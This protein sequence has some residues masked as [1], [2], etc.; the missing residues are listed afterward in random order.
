M[1]MEG[2]KK[3]KRVFMARVIAWAVLAAGLPIA[4]IGWRYDLF[5]KVGAL[6]LSGWGMFAVV[7]LLFFARALAKYI[8]A[9]FVEWSMWKQII[10]GVAKIVLPLG[11]LLAICVAI[12]ANVEYFIQALS[13]TLMCEIMAI[14]VNPFPKWVW[15]KSKGRFESYIDYMADRIRNGKEE[16]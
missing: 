9:G 15:E 2:D 7:I 4:F 6:Q 1:E 5:A 12:R 16:K 10:G 13:C 8:K 3:A 14:P 11:G